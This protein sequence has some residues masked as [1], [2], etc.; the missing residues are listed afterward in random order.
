MKM[1]KTKS[2]QH[3]KT[4]IDGNCELFGV[5]IFEYQWKSTGELITVKDPAYQQEHII[6]VYE[7]KINDSIQTFAAGE[8]SNCVWGFYLF[9]Y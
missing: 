4:G 1:Y 6:S 3:V 9:K 8:F 5:N 7:V 2:W